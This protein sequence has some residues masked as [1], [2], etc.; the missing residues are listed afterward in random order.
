MTEHDAHA[1]SPAPLLDEHDVPP[2]VGA[3]PMPRLRRLDAAMRAGAT[4]AAR[5]VWGSPARRYPAL[6]LAV[7]A[8]AVAGVLTYLELRVQ[9]PP[10]FDS[11]RIDV[12]FEY[13]LL[14]DDFNKLPVEE[15]LALV[16]KLVERMKSLGGNDSV[17]LAL[18][19]SM[20]AGEARAQLE[21]NVSRAAVDLFDTYALDYD[22]TAP[23]ADREA[24]LLDTFLEFGKT[25]EALVGYESDQTDE[26][27]L[28]E[29]RE[30]AQRDL[31]AVRD[32]QIGAGDA[33]RVFD[34][35][36]NGMGRHATGHQ[37]IRIATMTRDMVEML[38]SGGP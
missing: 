28:A 10:D 1:Q 27:R 18:F 32:G 17:L 12:L 23:K 13:T 15:R 35:L 36:N 20:I 29:A 2:E 3:P 19:A 5:W 22:V 25:M 31:Q 8:V 34:V 4:G 14:T 30:Q 38:R 37:K 7:G 6:G 33:L 11:A 24:Y 9:P 16:A 26:E 21:E